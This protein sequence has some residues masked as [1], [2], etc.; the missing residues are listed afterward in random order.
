MLQQIRDLLTDNQSVRDDDYLR[1][2]E[3][4]HAG[5]DSS[6]NRKQGKEKK[7]KMICL[8]DRNKKVERREKEEETGLL[9]H[10]YQYTCS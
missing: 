9:P 7:Q 4:D 6:M 1:E 5:D 8:A 3:G 2:T 10:D